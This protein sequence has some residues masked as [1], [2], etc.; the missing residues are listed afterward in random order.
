MKMAIILNIQVYLCMFFAVLDIEGLHNKKEKAAIINDFLLQPGWKSIN[1][2]EFI[3]YWRQKYV[4]KNLFIEPVT[5]Y[6]CDNYIRQA[7]IFLG[8]SYY[9]DLKLIFL[10]LIKLQEQC[11]HLLHSCDDSAHNCTV[12][13]LT[14]MIE[15]VPMAKFMK[16]ALYAIEKYHN[17][18][19]NTLT[20]TRFILSSLLTN[21][22]EDE[23][24]LTTLRISSDSIR[25]VLETIAKILFARRLELDE[26]KL[27]CQLKYLDFNSLCNLWNMEFN[28]LKYQ[29]KYHEF[30]I[31]LSDK[32]KNLILTTIRK[33]YI[34]LGF[35]YDSS[36]SETFLL[37]LPP[38]NVK[39][40]IAQKFT[41]NFVQNTNEVNAQEENQQHDLTK[42]P[43]ILHTNDVENKE[44]IQQEK[45]AVII[46]DF[47]RQP[48]WNNINDVELIKNCGKNYELKNLFIEP[49]TIHNCDNFIRQATI[50]LGC[51]YYHD[52]NLMFLSLIKF[53]QHCSDLLYSGNDSVYNCT[54]TLLTKMIEM[55]PMAKYMK[56]ALYAIEKYHITPLNTLKKTRFILSSILTKIQKDVSLLTE[57]KNKSDSIRDILV[58]IAKLLYARRLKLDVNKPFCVLKKLDFNSLWNSWNIEFNILFYEG[59]YQELFIFLSDKIRK[60]NIT[61]IRKK[62]IEL[63]FK[64][65]SSTSETF[66]LDLPP[67]NVKEDIAQKFTINFVQNTNE[68]NAQEENQQHY[69]T[70]QT[71]LPSLRLTDFEQSIAQN[72]TI[73]FIQNINEVNAQEEIQQHD[74]TKYP[75]LLNTNVVEKKES[76]QQEK[77][78]VIIN[79][80]LRQPG[81]NNI[82]DVELIKNCGK[83]YELKNLFIEPVTIHNCDNFIRQATIFLGCSY[84]HDLNLMF[85]SLIKFQQHCSDL[86]YSGNDSVYNCTVTLLTKI[87]EMV[88]LAKYMKGALYAIE[89][90]HIR[91]LNTL[92]KTRFIL[93]SILS[94]IQ[95]DETLLTVLKN[96]SDSISEILMTIAKLLYARRF[97]LDRNKSFCVLKQLDFNSLWNSWNI[98]FNTLFYEGKY[99][100]LFIFLSDKIRKLNITIIRKKYIELGFKYD[101]STSQTFLLALPS[102]NVKED[103]AQK[104]TINFVQN[105][106]EVNAQ[107]EN[108][109]FD[110]TKYPSILHTNDVVNK[111]GIQQERKHSKKENATIINNFLRQ[112]GWSNINDVELIKYCGKNYELKNLFIEPVTIHNCDNFIRQAT[113]FLGCSYYHDLKLIFL[114][115]IKLQEHCSDLLNSGNDSTYNCTVTL[116]I[117]MVEIV[118]MAKYMKGALYAIEKYHINP[119]NLQ[120]KIRFILSS[121]LTKIQKDETLLT[122][123]KISSDSIR[124][125][126]VTIAKILSARS[127]ELDENNSFCL[128]KQIDFNSLWNLWNIELNTLIYEGKYQKLFIFLSDKIRNLILTTIRKKYIELGFKFDYYTSQTILPGLRP[129]DFKQGIDQNFTI[130]FIQNPNEVNAQ[131]EIQ[132]YDLTKYPSLLHTNVVEKKEGIQQENVN[133][134][135]RDDSVLLI[136]Y[137]EDITK[138][139]SIPYTNNVE[140]QED[141][142]QENVNCELKDDSAVLIEYPKGMEPFNKYL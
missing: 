12:T 97:K 30:F 22:Q 58:T 115:L 120:K 34:E 26:E 47:L 123:L 9:H 122:T 77:N 31:F 20:R 110:L 17:S 69:Y 35:K 52:L 127:L 70:S 109:H 54:V 48:G 138:Y 141:I 142:R 82:N 117:K 114:S 76:I 42:Y 89:K 94:K 7:T 33:K 133:C 129:T 10:S 28:N 43:S 95:K 101:S 124:D 49:V 140:K 60:L 121:I 1:D 139:P 61:I 19:L 90:Y 36:T 23:S 100:E 92:K 18:P 51:S 106:N 130:N 8:C 87:I 108:Q 6:N 107:E 91:P 55:V 56:G 131:E 84:Y 111:E 53:Q 57:L 96:K 44:G 41:I 103:I 85:L 136:E 102:T 32:I 98:E 134:D 83:N 37:G 14:K 112:P 4:L 68:V 125:V 86:L 15:I 80:F 93:S 113:I 46:N 24:L 16:G 62:Y 137:P 11:L 126:L 119:L 99:Q 39:E 132:H 3:N 63:G 79:D 50:F 21:I 2:V 104:F 118:P 72:C 65:D 38:T 67:T 71:I 27:F 59:K 73:N 45:N 74:L 29:G 88:P 75:S 116:L 40:D 64:Y 78:A 135:F 5:L 105:T 66:L 13:L 81:W 128:L 25:D